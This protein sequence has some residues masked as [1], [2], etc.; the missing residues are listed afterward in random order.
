MAPTR[1]RWVG[2]SLT[3]F[4]RSRL[5][6]LAGRKRLT[7][8]ATA[9]R[10]LAQ[11][12]VSSLVMFGLSVMGEGDQGFAFLA[13]FLSGAAVSFVFVPGAFTPDALDYRPRW[14]AALAKEY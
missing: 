5:A 6:C 9:A 8:P 11:W 1:S 4:C 2:P 7:T 3:Y 12:A 13:A 10:I 14:T